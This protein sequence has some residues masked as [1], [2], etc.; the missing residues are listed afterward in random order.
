M[1]YSRNKVKLQVQK[2]TLTTMTTMMIID[3]VH[4]EF[5]SR[6]GKFTGHVELFW[7]M[8]PCSDVV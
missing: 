6:E 1:V 4:C 2:T 8:T 5:C 7:V 3:H